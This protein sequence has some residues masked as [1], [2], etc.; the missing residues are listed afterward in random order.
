MTVHDDAKS[1]A[2][3]RPK[4]RGA[5]RALAV[6]AALALIDRAG[7]EAATLDAIA[8]DLGLTKQGLYYHFASKEALLADAALSDWKTMA[9]AVY[10]AT[11]AATCAEAALEALVRTCMN[12]YAGRLQRYRLVTQGALL[13]ARAADHARAMLVAIHPL[14]ELLYGPTERKLRDAQATGQADPAL[15]P[16]RLAFSAH[17][18]AMGLLTMKLMA[19]TLGDPLRHNDEGLVA[20]ICRTLRASVGRRA[21]S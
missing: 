12:H 3:A 17:M 7:I 19:S 21:A 13:S 1:A 16:R 4:Q 8:S 6:D 15:D 20:E 9:T 5:T 11:L 10:A 2:R 14:N 18:A